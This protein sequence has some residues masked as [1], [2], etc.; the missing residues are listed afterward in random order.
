MGA[1][2]ALAASFSIDG[3]FPDVQ[4]AY[5]IVTDALEL[6]QWC[7]LQNISF[8]KCTVKYNLKFTVCIISYMRLLDVFL[9][10]ITHISKTLFSILFMFI[11]F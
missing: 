3:A 11:I 7:P 10:L 4:A 9:L 6:M 1:Y 5:S 8:L 2:A